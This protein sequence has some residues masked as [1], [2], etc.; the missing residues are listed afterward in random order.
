M[1]LKELLKLYYGTGEDVTMSTPG[2]ITDVMN[3]LILPGSYE[4][5]SKYRK[6]ISWNLDRDVFYREA[7]K[8]NENSPLYV[9]MT[10][11]KM[12]FYFIFDT[13]S[14]FQKLLGSGLKKHRGYRKEYLPWDKSREFLYYSRRYE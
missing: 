9:T 4:S 14:E 12:D 10:T 5:P 7:T 13:D 11:G 6:T 8:E 2:V 3:E 1:K